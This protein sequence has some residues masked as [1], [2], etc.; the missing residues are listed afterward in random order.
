MV[1]K[2]NKS[3]GTANE[4]AQVFLFE[5][6]TER[7]NEFYRFWAI[8]ESVLKA[9]GAG[10]SAMQPARI[11]IYTKRNACPNARVYETH[12][13]RFHLKSF[14]VVKIK[15]ASVRK[16]RHVRR[17]QHVS[18]RRRAAKCARFRRAPPRGRRRVLSRR[19]QFASRRAQGRRATR[20]MRP[21]AMAAS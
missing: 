11:E 2:N 18:N 14:W 5:N 17:R 1:V 15:F 9:T 8:K 20:D 7:L 10:A 13:Q 4:W 21:A 6:A 19:D 16:R 12:T 3:L